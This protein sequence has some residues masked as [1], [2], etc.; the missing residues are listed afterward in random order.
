MKKL[1]HDFLMIVMAAP[2]LFA[3]CADNDVYDPSKVRPVAPVENPLGDDFVA[4]DGFD[5]SMISTVKLN[6]E[7][8]D[9]F[10]GQYN[11]LI[12]VF[13]ADPLDDNNTLSPI[14]AGYAKKGANY[15]TEISIPKS[16]ERLFIRQ[17]T[18]DKYK[19]VYGYSLPGN[20]CNLNCKLYYTEEANT[21]ANTRTDVTGTSGWDRIKDPGYTEEE[22]SV[23]ANAKAISGST[24]NGSWISGGTFVIKEG[25]TYLGSFSANNKST[26]Y[27]AGAWTPQNVDMQKVDIIVLKGGRI[28]STGDFHVAD[29]SS[30]TIQSGASVAFNSFGT[31]TNRVIKNFGN[32]SATRINRS[33]VGFNSGT[34]LYN[35]KDATF[36]VEEN[37]KVTGSSIYNHGKI[38]ITSEKGTFESNSN[39]S[40]IANY[41]QAG[42]KVSSLLHFG[43]IVNSGTIDTDVCTNKAGGSLYNNCLLIARNNFQYTT[44]ELDHGSITGGR[45][46]TTNEWLPVNDFTIGQPTNITLKNGSI[47]KANIF[48]INNS[49]NNIEGKGTEKS[50]IKIQNRYTG[51]QGNTYIRGNLVLEGWKSPLPGFIIIDSNIPR[52]GYDDS[53][54]TIENCAGIVNEGNPGDPD[55]EDPPTP[56][57][58]DNTVYTY[59]FEDQ[60]P[61]YGDFDMNDVVITIDKINTTDGS[62]QVS[63]QGRIRAVGASR[64]T[65]VGIQ[66]LNVNT[67]GVTLS[68]KVQNGT[69]IFEAGQKNPVVILCTNAHQY[70][71]PNIANDDFTFYCTDPAVGSEYNSGDGANFEIIMV[72]PSAEEA[73]KAVIVKNLDV[74]IISQ[75]AQGSV[76][77]TE[78]HMANYAPTGLANAALFGMGNDASTY[79]N[80]LSTPGKGYYISAEG[81]AWGICIPSNMAWN[82]PREYKIIKDVYPYFENWVTSGGKTED[83]DWINNHNGDIFV[84]P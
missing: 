7:V 74:F 16:I 37:F 42:I 44:I 19:E 4:P 69:P 36:T 23:P 80:L 12:E 49:V 75:E 41:P 21:R 73:Q 8:K 55:P 28:T 14:A 9:E 18:P 47:I 84:K 29:N 68:G 57:I 50:M 76:G 54:Y 5:W 25:D 45:S 64:K 71:K 77:R 53:K 72:F 15:V 48:R 65:G 39:G 62:K 70:C 35:G 46:E 13:T 17:T 33:N 60:W 81:L 58:G 66:F 30:L 61:A 34:V 31:T 10:N 32:F 51:S 40:S 56:D 78:V 1:K 27:V 52:T 2:L 6:V 22:I 82:W 79:N 83:I 38:E 67:S 26:L 59:A 63:I 3:A 43:L 20:D 11:Y 24:H